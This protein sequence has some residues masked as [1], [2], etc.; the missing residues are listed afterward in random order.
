M[1]SGRNKILAMQ[2]MRRSY[3]IPKEQVGTLGCY[4]KHYSSYYYY[5]EIKCNINVII[6]MNDVASIVI[7][8]DTGLVK[9]LSEWKYQSSKN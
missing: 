4:I 5:E 2:Q 7:T 9:L 1:T 6:A 3:D 8:T